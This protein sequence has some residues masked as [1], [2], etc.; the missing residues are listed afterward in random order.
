MGRLFNGTV[1][2]N[3]QNKEIERVTKEIEQLKNN[4]GGGGGV[5]P[6][7]LGDTIIGTFEDGSV[8][9]QVRWLG[10]YADGITLNATN[11]TDIMD[12][13]SGLKYIFDFHTCVEG[14]NRGPSYMLPDVVELYP[15]ISTFSKIV[16]S[17][18]TTPN[19]NDI[20][21]TY[22]EFKYITQ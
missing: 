14:H 20:K 4:S 1:T 19:S 15:S 22:Y 9:H 5:S 2:D 11:A 8:L 3:V 12:C 18:V 7:E 21:L 13:P 10:S 17:Q 6:T 16:A